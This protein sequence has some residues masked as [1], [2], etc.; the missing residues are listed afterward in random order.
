VNTGRSGDDAV[1]IGVL[2][3][4]YGRLDPAGLAVCF[5]PLARREV[6]EAKPRRKG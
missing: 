1:R 3:D 5:V 6:D 2:S 4:N